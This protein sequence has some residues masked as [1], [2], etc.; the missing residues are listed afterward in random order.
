MFRSAERSHKLCGFIILRE[1]ILKRIYQGILL[2]CLSIERYC[3]LV[4]VYK[5][6][7]TN[8]A[9]LLVIISANSLLLFYLKLKQEKQTTYNMHNLFRIDTIEQPPCLA[10]LLV[11][12]LDMAYQFCLFWPANLVPIYV[13]MVFMQLFL[14]LN[15]LMSRICCGREEHKRHLILS[16]TILIGVGISI[17]GLFVIFKDED[18]DDKW[19]FLNYSILFCLG[20]LLNVLSQ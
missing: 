14:P 13:L 11:G 5:T 19:F 1:S 2:I 7:C 9:L 17:G 3:F 12:I 16:I 6:K 10:I 20:Q 4:M 18:N 8:Y 15:T